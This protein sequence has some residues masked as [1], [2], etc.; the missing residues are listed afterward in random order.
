MSGM[1]L[2]GCKPATGGADPSDGGKPGEKRGFAIGHG[3]TLDFRWAPAGSFMTGGPAAGPGGSGGGNERAVVIAD[4]FWIA[5]NEI[6]VATWQKVMGSEPAMKDTSL[7][8]PVAQVSWSDC[9]SFLKR[10]KSPASGWNYDL[11]SEAQWEYACRAGLNAASARPPAK[12]GWIDAN[13]GGRRRPVAITPPDA[14]S[15][16]D[17]HGNVAEWC[18][19]DDEPNR[20]E[21]AIRSGPVVRNADDPFLRINNIGFRL[22]LVRTRSSGEVPPAPDRK[23]ASASQP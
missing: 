17:M 4:G 3:E 9:R 14:W 6:T 5:E 13:P 18:R 16:R 22:I 12:L 21:P 2:A 7:K 11:P 8:K 15:I 20:S 23:I 1:L 19:D 10:V